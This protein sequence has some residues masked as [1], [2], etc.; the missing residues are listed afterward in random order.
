MEQLFDAIKLRGHLRMQLMDLSG[1][2][3]RTLDFDNLCVTQGRS[4]VL[5]QLQSVNLITSQVLNY[6]AV[7]SGGA[8]PTT[9]DT[10]L[11]NEVTRLIVGTWVTSTLTA[12]PPSWQAQ[13]LLT[14]NVAN[15]TL[16]EI[17]IFN[18][19]AAGTMLGHQ[20]F[21]SFVKATSNTLGISY[22]ISG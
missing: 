6:I 9:A 14:T 20:T 19:S 3:L 15:T 11:G 2:V 7:G 16:S 13:A 10:A 1:E 4:W 22:T 8:A 21:S 17:G 5:G 18:S 12:N